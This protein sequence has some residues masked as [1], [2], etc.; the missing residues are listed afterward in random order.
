MSGLCNVQV[1]ARTKHTDSRGWLIKAIDG[2][3]PHLPREVGEVYVVCAAPGQ[4]RANH[5]HPA[6]SEWFTIVRGCAT[7]VVQHPE[8]RERG[9]WHLCASDP[10]TIY[11]PKGLAHAIVVSSEASEPTMLIA[12]AD[13]AYDPAD[14]VKYKVA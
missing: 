9:E 4:V 8:S 13:R 11:V 3:E 1:I 2:D 6:T 14:T 10:K 5:Y 12:Y 7:I